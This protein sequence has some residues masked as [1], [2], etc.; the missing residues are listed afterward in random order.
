MRTLAGTF[1]SAVL[2]PI[3]SQKRAQEPAGQHPWSWKGQACKNRE[4]AEETVFFP[5]LK[6][7][8]LGE[9]IPH[10]R[11]KQSRGKCYECPA[12]VKHAS[13]LSAVAYMC[14]VSL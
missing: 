9:P 8:L 2:F 3:A 14:H 1:F 12:A 10:C 6:G 5:S 13:L 7:K 4:L 11:T